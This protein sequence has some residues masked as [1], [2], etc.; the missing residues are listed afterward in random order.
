MTIPHGKQPQASHTYV[1]HREALVDKSK[2]KCCLKGTY[3]I[4]AIQQYVLKQEG[5]DKEYVRLY[6]SV[7]MIN[8]SSHGY[9]KQRFWVARPGSRLESEP[10]P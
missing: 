6:S 3:Y 9:C 1:R 10:W 8:N 4:T 2:T 5:L 7:Q